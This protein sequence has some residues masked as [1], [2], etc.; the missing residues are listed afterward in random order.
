MTIV[1]ILSFGAANVASAHSGLNDSF[2]STTHPSRAT[3]M[4]GNVDVDC[5]SWTHSNTWIAAHP[6]AP[7]GLGQDTDN[8]SLCNEWEK[9]TG[10][11][12]DFQT[13][14]TPPSGVPA[15]HDFIYH[16]DCD[17]CPD[18][19]VRDLYVELDWMRDPTNNS[20]APSTGVIQAVKDAFAAAPVPITL[21]V[22]LGEVPSD[23]IRGGEIPFH[24]DSIRV[25]SSLSTPPGFY[26]LKEYYFGT[27]ADRENTST[28]PY[29]SAWSPYPDSIKDRLTAKR[30]AFH[31]EMIIYK[32]QEN[33]NSGW[34]EV[35]GNDF[36]I[37]LGT[38][39]PS[40]GST[41]QQKGTMMHEI[42]HNLNLRHGGNQDTNCKPNYLSI[43]SY[44]FQ[45]AANAD[46]GR[47]LDFSR[48]R[49]NDI[50]EVGGVLEQSPAVTPSY[51]YS[52]GGERKIFYSSPSG[53]KIQ[54][55]VNQAVNWNQNGVDGEATSYTQN[56]N[57]LSSISGCADSTNTNL[58]GYDDWANLD[59]NFLDVSFGQTGAGSDV[60]DLAPPDVSEEELV[61]WSGTDHNTTTLTWQ[62]IENDIVLIDLATTQGSKQLDIKKETAQCNCDKYDK[63]V[64]MRNKWT[65]SKEISYDVVRDF[66]NDHLVKVD[67]E[68]NN[69]ND[70][71]F[72]NG[73]SDK[74]ALEDYISK[75]I[76][77][78]QKDDLANVSENLSALKGKAEDS[79][80]NDK[81]KSKLLSLVDDKIESF[82]IAQD[83]G[84]S[85]QPVDDHKKILDSITQLNDSVAKLSDSI[86]QLDNS[87]NELINKVDTDQNP[88]PQW[89]L[90]NIILGL[91][92]AA[93]IGIPLAYYA[94]KHEIRKG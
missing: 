1:S 43:M 70:T 16:Y 37:S 32:Q 55:N 65:T 53:T 11:E 25:D 26:R 44:T 35:G 57:N 36:V 88:N 58:T 39:T 21:H 91:I 71:E 61:D 60:D 45:F 56:I 24:K 38:F 59:F 85:N 84:E 27:R 46:S 8:D 62:G 5:S 87:V 66:Y 82:A 34:A 33:S 42:G 13:S 74:L 23:S 30:Q 12:I 6:G 78:N 76:N 9:T 77:A 29:W 4:Y 83:T 67:N 22:Q 52:T 41:D 14:G 54:D 2:S 68:I 47:P 49:L 94:S 93:G 20:H 48:V 3:Y 72:K 15:N 69:I 80:V 90:S 63:S 89:N 50:N 64:V 75:A 7:T 86:N 17:P 40:M 51:T 28:S 79:I 10:L 19:N 81:V 31:Y 18:P 92:I 73:K